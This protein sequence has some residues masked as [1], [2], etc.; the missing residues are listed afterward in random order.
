[1][2]MTQTRMKAA[3]RLRRKR[4][5][6]KKVFGTAERPRLTIF[7]SLNHMYAQVI[8]DVSGRTVASAGTVETE[9]RK[10]ATGNRAAAESVGVLIAERA[11]KAGIA[12]VV[13]DRNGFIYHG[14]VKSLAD[15][16]R[17]GGLEF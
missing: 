8:D 4:H 5:I 2:A 16:A 17:K 6:R 11:K 14:R 1:M 3:R 15:A 12:K 10:K 13:F 7:R 9:A